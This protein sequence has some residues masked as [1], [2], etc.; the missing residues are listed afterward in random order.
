MAAQR[1]DRFK[2][3]IT[4]CWSGPGVVV[5]S[6]EGVFVE[7]TAQDKTEAQIVPGLVGSDGVA[8]GGAQE[9]FAVIKTS[10]PTS[11]AGFVRWRKLIRAPLPNI[12]PQVANSK[13]IG[14]KTSNGRGFRKIV[15]FQKGAIVSSAKGRGE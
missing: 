2:R 11:H 8:M 9:F 4:E 5:N 12:P 1:A 13:V 3:S 6:V 15:G 7:L 14:R 10:G